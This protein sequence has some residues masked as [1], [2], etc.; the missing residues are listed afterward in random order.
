M[1]VECRTIII[2]SNIL[3]Q[4]STRSVFWL[5]SSTFVRQSVFSFFIFS[6]HSTRCGSLIIVVVIESTDFFFY[7]NSS[8]SVSSSQI[9]SK[10]MEEKETEK[11]QMLEKC[12]E[13]FQFLWV[14]SRSIYLRDKMFPMRK[15]Y[16]NLNT[17]QKNEDHIAWEIIWF[18]LIFIGQ[19]IN[20]IYS[21]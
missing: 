21:D 6:T 14:V 19:R 5:R 15:S 9:W 13:V 7:Y 18:C 3:G 8:T 12:V 1:L 20:M 4:L 2:S 16:V 11:K 17:V 10:L